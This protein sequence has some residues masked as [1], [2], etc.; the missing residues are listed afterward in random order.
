[1]CPQT[2]RLDDRRQR[3]LLLDVAE[4]EKEEP[5]VEAP[6]MAK[7]VLGRIAYSPAAASTARG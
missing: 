2:Q 6:Y 4:M 5:G 1:M 7:T 3:A